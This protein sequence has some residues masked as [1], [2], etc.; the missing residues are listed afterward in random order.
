MSFS[1]PP[2]SCQR[3]NFDTLEHIPH[4]NLRHLVTAPSN[5][6]PNAT[7]RLA[8][9]PLTGSSAT[10]C[11]VRVSLAGWLTSPLAFLPRLSP[12]GDRV[13]AEVART[14]VSMP[15]IHPLLWFA[16]P[17]KVLRQ[18]KVLRPIKTVSNWLNISPKSM[19]PTSY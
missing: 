17:S 2:G 16:I 3:A 7:G 6:Q 19:I 4:L 18:T 12:S 1:T 15:G 9:E 10:R 14:N 8:V 11:P 5:H 13:G